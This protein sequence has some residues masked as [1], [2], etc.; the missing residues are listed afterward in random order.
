MPHIA[1]ISQ[2][3]VELRCRLYKIAQPFFNKLLIK[4]PLVLTSLKDND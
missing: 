2:E 4:M 3:S 1:Q